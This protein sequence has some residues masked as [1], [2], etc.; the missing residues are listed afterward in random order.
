MKFK[1]TLTLFAMVLMT[2]Y[3]TAQELIWGGPGD[4]NS[5]FAGGLNDWT[6]KGLASAVADSSKNA[7]WVWDADGL[8]NNGAYWGSGTAIE[9]PSVANGVALFN[10]DF[11]DNGGIQGAFGEGLAPSPHSSELISPIID[12]SGFST[13][14]L[15][16]YQKF[17]NFDASTTVGVSND[18]GATFTEF[19]LN[20]N[21]S[22]NDVGPLSFVTLNISN[23]AA[24]QDS[25]VIKFKFVGDYYYWM[26]DDVSIIT[27]PDNN[28][29]ITDNETSPF[30]TPYSAVAPACAFEVDTFAFATLASNLGADTIRNVMYKVEIINNDV[31]ELVYTDSLIIDFLPPGYQDTALAIVDQWAPEGLVQGFYRIRHSISS[32][33]F[34][35]DFDPTDNVVSQFFEVSDNVFAKELFGNGGFGLWNSGSF[36][37]IGAFYQFGPNCLENYTIGSI[38]YAVG[39]VSADPEP[40]EGRNVEF[41]V[42]KLTENFNNFNTTTDY[43]ADILAVDH[44]SMDFVAFA[45]DVLDADDADAEIISMDSP[46]FDIDGEETNVI[47]EPGATYGIFTHWG[48]NGTTAPLH[49]FTS[50][51]NT[52]T[53]L[54]Y[55]GGW[56]GGFTGSKSAPILRLVL[57]LFSSVDEKPL[58]EEAFKVYPNPASDLLNIEVNLESVSDATITIANINGQVINYRNISKLSSDIITLNVSDYVPGAYLA[59]IATKEGTKTVKFVVN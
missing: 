11:L 47:F 34:V 7:I 16:F 12:I 21:V 5:E 50:D 49:L 2:S 38:D 54:F 32:L 27:L 18:G 26:V 25:V 56:F 10:S 23:V 52:N 28:L 3:M 31:N 43:E 15:T 20:T 41:W 35:D 36:Y 46:F 6:T 30:Y 44:P 45:P 59:R 40:L 57:S 17:R 42:W 1:F 51:I 9:S 29:A 37:A 33:D 39:R 8:A 4:P 53:D 19:S 24:G 14:A 13:A 58:A 22:A 48:V 55:A